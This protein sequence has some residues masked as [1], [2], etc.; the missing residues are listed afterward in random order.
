[1]SS[2]N[3]VAIIGRPNV[4]KSTL[5]NVITEKR[6]AVVLDKP[7]VT[8]DIQIEPADWC[9]VEFDII[10]TG[11]I[12][13]LKDTYSPLIKESVLDIIKSVH[14]LV[15][16]MDG[17][18]GVCPEDRDLL[19]IAQSSGKPYLVVLNK[20]D[21]PDQVEIAKADFYELGIDPIA[22]AFEKRWGVDIILDWCLEQFPKASE[23][24]EL[25]HVTMT[26][27]GKPNAGKSSLCNRLLGEKRMLVSEHAGTTVDAIDSDFEYRDKK[28]TLIDTAGIR[29]RSR[30]KDDVEIIASFKSYDAIQR[31]QIVLLVIDGTVGPADR[32]AK[33]VEAILAKNRAVILVANKVDLTRETPEFRKTFRE[34]VANVFHFF[35]DI[36]IAFVSATT[37]AGIESLFDTIDDVWSKINI[38]I[39]T[40]ELNDFFFDVIRQ[41]PAPV[42]G[43]RDVKFFYLVQTNQMLP[44]FI[45]FVNYPEG[46]DNAYRRFLSKR[47]KERWN[48]EGVP[49][50]IYAMKRGGRSLSASAK[51]YGPELNEAPEL[52]EEVEVLEEI[53][54]DID[55]SLILDDETV[56]EL[57]REP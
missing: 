20:V 41:T 4:G 25:P 23:K 18:A 22:V 44:S 53:P 16:V 8:R 50:R 39:K 10:D 27:I 21:S 43:V 29:R 13:E 37:G 3:R 28:Y 51:D 30:Q 12:T 5:F 54:E 24:R 2:R 55:M 40:R 31:A 57:G 48:L 52:L 49:I 17:R 42:H 47:I 11:G 6:K 56:F 26:I 45:A 38:E 36:P 35:Q 9:G 7:G 1:M 46:V 15:V 19:R 34:K 33:I 32:D 14:A